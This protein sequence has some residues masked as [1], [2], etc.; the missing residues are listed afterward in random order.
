VAVG[1]DDTS[2]VE[3]VN[4]IIENKGGISVYDGEAT[5]IMSLPIAGLMSD[6]AANVVAAQYEILDAKAKALGSKLSAPFMTLSFM[7]LPVIPH[8]KITD[9]GMFD[10]D[11]FTFI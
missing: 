11:K 8:L 6:Q 5:S 1:V 3:A 7:A 2:I 9:K 10:V 4:A